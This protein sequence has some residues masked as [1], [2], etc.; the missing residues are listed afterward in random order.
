MCI[1]VHIPSGVE[2]FSVTSFHLPINSHSLTTLL[3]I[4][5]LY[6]WLRFVRN[7]SVYHTADV[8]K[9]YDV[10]RS[11]VNN[12]FHKSI[13]H[14]HLDIFFPAACKDDGLESIIVQ[15]ERFSLF[16]PKVICMCSC[17]FHFT[18]EM[19]IAVIHQ[20]PLSMPTV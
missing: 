13:L 18:K 8:A 17:S 6:F 5:L 12:P 20:Y 9:V 11:K 10:S 7:K 16:A 1:Y 14:W 2:S 4:I 3:T 15:C 19:S